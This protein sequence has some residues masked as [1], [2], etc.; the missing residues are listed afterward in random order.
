ML[1]SGSDDST[2]ILWDFSLESWQARVCRRAN[3]NLTQTEWQQV[4]GDQ[5]YRATCPDLPVSGEAN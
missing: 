2:L 5:P 1:A 4:F 3:R